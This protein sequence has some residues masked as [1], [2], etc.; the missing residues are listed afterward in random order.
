MLDEDFHKTKTKRRLKKKDVPVVPLDSITY[1]SEGIAKM[2]KF[3]VNKRIVVERDLFE[4]AQNYLEIMNLFVKPSIVC[5]VLN[6]GPYYPQLVCEFYVN[7]SHQFDNEGSLDYRKVHVNEHCFVFSAYLINRFL[8]CQV[9]ENVTEQRSFMSDLVFELT[10]RVKRAWPKKD[11]LPCSDL[12]VKYVL[13]H[14]IGI[15]NWCPSSHKYSLSTP[16]ENLLYQIGTMEKFNYGIF[17]LNQIKRHI[18]SQATKVP[19]RVSNGAGKGSPSTYSDIPRPLP[20]ALSFSYILYKVKH[21]PGLV[22][23]DV[24]VTESGPIIKFLLTPCRKKGMH[25]LA[26]K[27]ID[28]GSLAHNIYARNTE[29]DDVLNFLRSTL[30]CPEQGG[31]SGAQDNNVV[32]Y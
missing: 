13:L 3:V 12:S 23:I 2:W 1:H 30:D 29:V 24:F 19:F 26:N 4:Q 7:L 21:V 32:E 20:P 15:E 5:S 28:L 10:R 6:F 14:K 9:P 8:N 18:A 25:G 16:L 11:Q 31:S 22:H 27:S 17:I